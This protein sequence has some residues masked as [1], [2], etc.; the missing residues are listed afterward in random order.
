MEFDVPK[1][2]D[3]Y[4]DF[5]KKLAAEVP[6]VFLYTPEY[7]YPVSANIHGIDIQTLISPAKRFS[8]ISHWYMKTKRIWKK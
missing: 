8:D 1:R 6:A 5:Q 7:I 2:A 4:S 3:I